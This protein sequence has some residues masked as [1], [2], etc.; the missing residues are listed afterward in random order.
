MFIN[1]PF[2]FQS[3]LKKSNNKYVS[4]VASAW[5]KLADATAKKSGFK[6]KKPTQKFRRG[7]FIEILLVTLN[8]RGGM[9]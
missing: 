7:S 9:V 5:E 6:N 4:Q 2:V 3:S 1:A 8:I